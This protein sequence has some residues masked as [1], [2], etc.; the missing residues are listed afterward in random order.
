MISWWSAF[1]CWNIRAGLGLLRELLALAF[2]GLF[3]FWS[4]L[5]DFFPFLNFLEGGWFL[6][7]NLIGVGLNTDWIGFYW[8]ELGWNFVGCLVVVVIDNYW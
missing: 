2:R 8:A 6:L 3:A 5:L 4:G 7:T 1:S